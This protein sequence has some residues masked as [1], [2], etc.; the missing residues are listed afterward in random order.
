MGRNKTERKSK[1]VVYFFVNR[2]RMIECRNCKLPVWFD[3]PERSHAGVEIDVAPSGFATGSM[4]E[5]KKHVEAHN[6]A[7]DK[8]YRSNLKEVSKFFKIFM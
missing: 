5:F 6:K 3:Q 1:R 8:V 4:T 2:K 7:G